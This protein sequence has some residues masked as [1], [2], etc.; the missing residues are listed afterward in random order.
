[1]IQVL[2]FSSVCVLDLTGEIWINYH[3]VNSH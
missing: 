1:M 3:A 2:T